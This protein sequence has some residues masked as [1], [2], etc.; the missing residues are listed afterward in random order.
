MDWVWYLFAFDG[1]INRAKIWLAILIIVCWMLI[2]GMLMLGISEMFGNPA[3]SIHFNTSDVFSFVDPPSLRA[4][5]ARLRDGR[6]PLRRR[7]LFWRCSLRRRNADLRRRHVVP[8]RCHG[9][10]PA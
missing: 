6:K 8:H 4:A 1:R 5:I 3:K 9:Q 2:I 7:R 10:A